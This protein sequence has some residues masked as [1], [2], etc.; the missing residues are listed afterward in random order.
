MMKRRLIVLF[1]LLL[2]NLGGCGNNTKNIELYN[3][4][5]YL[6]TE[7]DYGKDDFQGFEMVY[8][9]NQK[10]LS[11]IIDYSEYVSEVVLRDPSI[12][13]PQVTAFKTIISNLNNVASEEIG[14]NDINIDLIARGTY[15]NEKYDL[16]CYKNLDLDY[17]MGV[18]NVRSS[19]SEE[20]LRNEKLSFNTL[21]INQ[22]YKLVDT[23][24]LNGVKF[25]TESSYDWVNNVVEVDFNSSNLF[26]YDENQE[27]EMSAVRVAEFVN[28]HDE[29]IQEANNRGHELN[30]IFYIDGDLLFDNGKSPELIYAMVNGVIE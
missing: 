27:E 4:E 9:S 18:N 1:L 28:L 7:L 20:G 24:T 23:F 11:V 29:L 22:L 13:S 15:H 2:M 19:L 5:A 14:E 3:T 10:T 8:D 26:G 6:Q 12:L 25:D 16:F 17:Q 21:D 30:T